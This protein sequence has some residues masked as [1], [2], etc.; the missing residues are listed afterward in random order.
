MSQILIL[1]DEL[2]LKLSQ[3]AAERGLTIE[4]LL[5][6]VSALRAVPDRATERSRRIDRLL[7]RY[8]RGKINEKDCAELNHLIDADYQAASACADK[9]IAAKQSRQGTAPS[10]GGSKH[11]SPRSSKR[12]RIP[13]MDA[14]FQAHVDS[15]HASFERLIS[16]T[17]VKVCALPNGMPARGVY[18][19][20]EGSVHLYVGRTNRLRQR[21]KEHCR[22]SSTHNSAPFAFLLA[23]AANGMMAASHQA[24]GSRKQLEAHATFGPVFVAAKIRVSNMD[25]R[26]IEENDPLRQALLEMY[27]AITLQTPHNSFENH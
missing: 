20:S 16:L 17:P 7:A 11:S 9:L 3:G 24:N 21:L 6:F 25:L 23:K 22:K 27:A 8:G 15:L 12:F 10:P 14:T 18:L 19:F 4:E 2:Y 1:P 26:Y 5:G 13:L